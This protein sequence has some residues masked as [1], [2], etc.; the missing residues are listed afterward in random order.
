MIRVLKA[1]DDGVGLAACQIGVL[2]RVIVFRT[3]FDSDEFKVMINPLVVKQSHNTIRSN[4][5]CLSYPNTYA[6]VERAIDVTVA[7][8]TL[9]GT[10]KEEKLE[11]RAAIIFQHENDHLEGVCAVGQ[12]WKQQMGILPKEPLIKAEDFGFNEP[13]LGFGAEGAEVKPNHSL[14]SDAVQEAAKLGGY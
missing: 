5:G 2:K 3:S 6:I 14:T 4:E 12:A 9:E 8:K 1:T 7:Y 10:D 13:N 11:G